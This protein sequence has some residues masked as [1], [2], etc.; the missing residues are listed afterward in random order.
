MITC[1][2]HK[3]HY[4]HLGLI[5]LQ[6]K[7]GAEGWSAEG[8]LQTRKSLL[9][10]VNG[11][12]NFTQNKKQYLPEI[13]IYGNANLKNAIPNVHQPLK[14]RWNYQIELLQVWAAT[15]M[16]ASLVVQKFGSGN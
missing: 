15:E 3:I 7:A 5:D 14:L 10:R 16:D 1:P 9:A 13:Q 11:H 4:K 12:T 2:V 6:Q 8:L